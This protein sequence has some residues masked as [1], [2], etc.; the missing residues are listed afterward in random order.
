MNQEVSVIFKPS[1][2]YDLIAVAKKYQ[3]KANSRM[4]EKEDPKSALKF[5]NQAIRLLPNEESLL[6]A[7]SL[8]R[9]NLPHAGLKGVGGFITPAPVFF[10]AFDNRLTA[11]H[12]Y[13]P[14]VSV[15]SLD[16]PRWKG[17]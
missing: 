5:C 15:L 3:E 4:F 7:R 8:C 11:V 6:A 14:A 10:Y 2:S 13:T 16:V 1:E 17:I 9:Y 12:R